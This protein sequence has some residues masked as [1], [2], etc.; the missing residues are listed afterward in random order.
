M[1]TGAGGEPSL[2]AGPGGSLPRGLGRGYRRN[3]GLTSAA[4]TSLKF[5][6]TGLSAFRK[7]LTNTRDEIVKL[8][9]SFRD[10]TRDTKAWYDQLVKA[11]AEMKRFQGQHGGGGFSGGVP[12]GT[13]SFTGLGSG[14]T[15]R[16]IAAL[17]PGR[18]GT[19]AAS[20]AGTT[21]A[22]AGSAGI[23]GEAALGPAGIAMAIAQAVSGAVQSGMSAVISRWQGLQ[24]PAAAY[25]VYGSRLAVTT[26]IG[27]ARFAGQLARNA[28]FLGG[29][30][31]TGQALTT[32]AA[33]GAVFGG[34]GVAGQSGA[35][36]AR[37]INTLQRLM[38]GL[39]AVDAAG[40]VTGLQTNI[41]Q[42]R[43]AQFLYGTA[44]RSTTASGMQKDVNQYFAGMFKAI[45]A[46][47]GG[48]RRGQ[49][50]TREEWSA[51]RAPGSALNI[52]LTQVLGWT[53]DQINDF[54]TWAEAQAATDPTGN[55]MFTG[56]DQQMQAVRGGEKSLATEVQ[57]T[58]TA[59]GQADLNAYNRQSGAMMTQQEANRW[60]IN[61]QKGLDNWLAGLNK[62]LAHV[63]GQAQ[64]S[65][66]G[67]ISSALSM[68]PVGV[69]TGIGSAIFGDVGDI[70]DNG[71]S[72]LNPDL[73]GRVGAMMRANP[74][75]Q[76]NSGY[77]N[78]NT[79][80][81]LWESGHPNMAAPG[82]S[83]HGR[84][85]AADLGPRS[86]MGW[87]NANAKRFGLDVGTKFGEPWH[88]QLAGTMIGDAQSESARV[89]QFNTEVASARASAMRA[90][91]QQLISGSGGGSSSGGGTGGGSGGSSAAPT[92]GPTSGT[93][94]LDIVEKALY[95][96]GFRG[97][98][99]I[100][101][102]AIPSRES[103]Y[104]ADAH[105][106]NPATKD[107]S[108]GP[109]Q[110]NAR[111]DAN[112]PLI[113]QILGTNDYTQLYDPYK[114][115][116][117]AFAMY[118]RNNNTLYPWGPYKGVS[119][120]HGVD[121]SA[122]DDAR[123]TAS[124]LWPGGYGDL[125]Y[126]GGGG[127]GGFASVHAPLN[128]TNHYH[129]PVNTNGGTVDVNRLV[130]QISAKLEPQIRRMQMTRR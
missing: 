81:R 37:S 25:D 86:E 70:G 95:T 59:Q 48:T 40:A 24:Q 22:T 21:G 34:G 88:V 111:P 23:A 92:S 83:R 3:R 93:V 79:Q 124:S 61:F 19:T 31:D 106:N 41:A 117:V 115:A 80:K 47:R 51:M 8:R 99:L 13:A 97:E 126:G 91:A 57:K 28:P 53:A 55:R 110:I 98:D 18:A 50:Y 128:I 82:K 60:M 67:I 4:Q 75:L 36:G 7:E 122:I 1:S 120:T 87:L 46:N 17:G 15:S 123:K 125:G 130:Q 10:L 121:Q 49:P 56:T 45:Q 103:K 9:G 85:Q 39:N 69:L 65:L 100:S 74:N 129:I 11:N 71:L 43:Q 107:D 114:S 84:G 108:Y 104:K 102:A 90:F 62:V 94:P 5:D 78:A 38:P 16:A 30:A 118:Q 6:I 109:W 116:Q 54:F 113:Q 14:T 2:G 105:N 12:G 66:P 64:G 33:Q 72:Q 77:R 119:A 52:Q 20:T 63:P 101:M 73:R 68:N 112:G 27:S 32:L 89:E 76:V 44:A 35:A 26:G 29:A 58:E 127:G 42:Q 96:A